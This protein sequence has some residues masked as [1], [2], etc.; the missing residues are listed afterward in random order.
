MFCD[1]I[2]EK[3]FV[4]EPKFHD[5]VGDLF[6]DCYYDMA[7]HLCG[8]YRYI[9]ETEH[10]YLS[11]ETAGVFR[12]DKTGPVESIEKEGEWIDPSI[13]ID[14]GF[15]PWVDIESTMFVG[16]RLLSVSEIEGGFLLK[17]DDFELRLLPHLALNE[18]PCDSPHAYSRVYGLEHLITRKCTCGGTGEIIID[19]VADFG[20]RCNKC[21]VGTYAHPCVCNAIDQWNDGIDLLEIGEYPAEAFK[22]FCHKPVEYIVFERFSGQPGKDAFRCNSIIARFGDRQF[23]IC[24]RYVGCGKYGFCFEDISNFNPEFWPKIIGAKKNAPISLLKKYDSSDNKSFLTF[25]VGEQF[26]SICAEKG[27]LVV[28][29]NEGLLED[30]LCHFKSSETT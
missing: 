19:F 30:T 16:E 1:E 2:I 6:L 10:F 28:K 15:D 23:K 5:S 8:N 20:I 17:F 11:L 12:H 4:G 14:E 26:I 18:F 7:I 24:S 22:R 25:R 3:V 9:L 29:L 21:H 13:Q 27:E